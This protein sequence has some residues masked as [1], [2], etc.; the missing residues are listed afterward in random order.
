[1]IIREWQENGEQMHMFCK[2]VYCRVC[3][4]WYT[5][6]DVKEGDTVECGNPS[7]SR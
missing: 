6:Y 1:M 3:R 2:Q 5:F 4:Q 7:W